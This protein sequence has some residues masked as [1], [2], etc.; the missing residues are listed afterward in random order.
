MS[1]PGTQFLLHKLAFGQAS[2]GG[3]G[4][5]QS[6]H[7]AHVTSVGGVLSFL[8]MDLEQTVHLNSI[9]LCLIFIFYLH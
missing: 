1:V 6:P 2:P 7:L 4:L 9:F 5:L 8:D 3:Q